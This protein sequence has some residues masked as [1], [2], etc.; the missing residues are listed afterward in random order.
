MTDPIPFNENERLAELETFH[1]RDRPLA[2]EFNNLSK[3]AAYLCNCEVALINFIDK[4]TQWS[5]SAYGIDLYSMKRCDT[6]CQYTIMDNCFYEVEDLTSDERFK[7]KFYVEDKP[8]LKFYGGFPLITSNGFNIGALCVLDSK[9]AK[10]TNKQKESLQTIANSIVTRLEIE[11]QN[12]LLKKSNDANS[13]LLRI[14][15]HDLRN[16][17]SGITGII[18]LLIEENLPLTPDFIYMLQL[19]KNASES[20]QSYT[21]DILE[22]GVALGNSEILANERISINNVISNLIEMYLPFAKNKSIKLIR[23]YPINELYIHSNKTQLSQLF[24][25]LLSNAIKFTPQ[26]GEIICSI[27]QDLNKVKIMIQD[28]GIGMDESILKNLFSNPQLSRR[29]G[30]EGENS[31]GLGLSMIKQLVEILSGTI[32]VRS[33]PSKGSTFTVHLSI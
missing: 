32:T 4:E 8:Y 11:K 29:S 28:N 2:S 33:E 19:V 6:V 16:P 3:L 18:N 1:L 21:N 22:S 15:G 24:G 23:N 26:N 14:I 12:H 9:P 27:S 31:T 5:K 7:Q 10:L 17:I 13:Q 30:T 25:N 20:M